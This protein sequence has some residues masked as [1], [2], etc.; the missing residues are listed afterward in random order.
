MGTHYTVLQADGGVSGAC[1]V[2][3]NNSTFLSFAASYDAYACLPG[4][5]PGAKAFAEAGLTPN[6]KAAGAGAESLGSG[7]L[8]CMAPS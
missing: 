3:G 2:L 8:A 7:R 1:T 5:G 6:Q 4:R